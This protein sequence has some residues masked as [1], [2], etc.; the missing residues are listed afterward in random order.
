MNLLMY[1][2]GSFNNMNVKF[3]K[4][5][6]FSTFFIIFIFI[7]LF[8][9][10]INIDISPLLRNTIFYIMLSPL[11]LILDFPQKS[12]I[13]VMV[14]FVL[15]LSISNIIF[16]PVS[17]PDSI[18][19][20]KLVSQFDNFKDLF[21]YWL[22]DFDSDNSNPYL[23]FG[24]FYLPFYLFWGF[25]DE[26]F[27]S[28]F[29]SFLLIIS[30]YL[31]YRSSKDYFGYPVNSNAVFLSVFVILLFFNGNLLYYNSVFLKDIT[32]LFWC[33]FAL[34]L[35]LK[36]KYLWFILI[37]I[38]ASYARVYAIV[39]I[40]C[41][42]IILKKK[43]KLAVFGFFCSLIF[44]FITTK[45]IGL[46]NLNQVSLSI[47]LSP[48]P[49]DFN[50]W[51]TFG[52]RTLDSFIVMIGIVLSIIVFLVKKDSRKFY[53][54]SLLSIYIYACMLTV[55]GS[56]WIHQDGLEY[57]IGSIGDDIARKKLPLVGVI[58]LICSY[59]FTRFFE[60][61]NRE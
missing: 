5:S 42:F 54:I 52:L 39:V 40:F 37:L 3:N 61:L 20:Y 19:Y 22:M 16:D 17:R 34:W 33:I 25:N 41:Y 60:I 28:V 44:V 49:F 31:I 9:L 51:S 45:F 48:L 29:N 59:S 57:T 55:A 47:L 36:K 7:A 23:N 38:I 4:I 12:K 24:I 21:N 50:N 58:Y 14:I 32:V 18:Y 46:I 15:G 27:I 8:I 53:L 26:Y 13:I 43:Y 1:M 11:I 6:L 2:K 56:M 30:I 35:L 10:L